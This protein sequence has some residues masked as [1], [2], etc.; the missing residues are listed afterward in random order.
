M[1]PPR[2]SEQWTPEDYETLR[3]LWETDAPLQDICQALGR[4]THSV[5]AQ[6]VNKGYAYFSTRYNAYVRVVPVPI[7][8]TTREL[9]QINTAT[10]PDTE[11]P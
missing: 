7:L 9:Q 10:W 2:G 5:A 3:L 11:T 6:L 8:W 1:K 4:S